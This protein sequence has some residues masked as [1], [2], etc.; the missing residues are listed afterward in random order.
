MS[1]FNIDGITI[2]NTVDENDMYIDCKLPDAIYHYTSK[3]GLLGILKGDKLHFSHLSFVNDMYEFLDIFKILKEMKLEIQQEA[4]KIFIK[5]KDKITEELINNMVEDI[6]NFEKFLDMEIAS[7]FTMSFCENKDSLCMWSNYTNKLGYNILVDP[8]EL[9][10]HVRD[11]I[12]QNNIIFT[13]G[14]II[15]NYDKK[16]E[17]IIKIFK[18]FFNALISNPKEGNNLR[19]RLLTLIVLHAPF[20]KRNILDQEEEIRFCLT[21]NDSIMQNYIKFKESNN[22]NIPYFNLDGDFCDCYKGVKIGP[23][24]KDFNEESLFLYLNP[25]K[26]EKQNGTYQNMYNLKMSRRDITKSEIAY[27]W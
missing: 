5:G 8:N 6:C 14:K 1:Y 2:K 24:A 19:L 12:G 25:M 21:V 23:L 20:F 18:D 16:K 26:N 4:K 10:R 3:E 17:I 9:K 11:S 15:Y 13:Y 7:V 22:V 27:K